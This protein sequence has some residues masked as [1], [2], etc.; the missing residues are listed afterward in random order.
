[1]LRVTL[2]L[3][4]L[5][6]CGFT[7][8]NPTTSDGDGGTMGMD[9]GD[10]D[11][12]PDPTCTQM[13]TFTASNFDPCAQGEPL[14]VL[15]LDSAMWRYSSID[16]SLARDGAV[17]M[18]LPTNGSNPRVLSLAGL[19]VETG[20]V[21][22][23][24]GDAP[25]IIGVHGTAMI[26]GRLDVSGSIASAGAGGDTC[27]GNKGADTSPIPA[28]GA[29]G[30]GG[31]GAFGS[32]GAAGGTGDTE[33]GTTNT[34]GGAAMAEV[35]D[36]MLVP[37]RGG[38]RGGAGGEEDPDAQSAGTPGSGGGG[39]GALQ[40][41]ARDMLEIGMAGRVA[42]NGGGGGRGVNAQYNGGPHV[43]VGGGG[44]GS[45]GAI[46]LESAVVSM[47][48]QAILCANGGGGGGGSH[49]N[50]NNA[51]GANGACSADAAIGGAG[52]NAGGAGGFLSTP[53]MPG[54]PGTRQDDGGGG[55]G[56]GVGRIRVRSISAAPGTFL[57]TPPAVID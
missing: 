23:I 30:G 57:S 36:P 47:H 39:G 3:L 9:G 7:I 25:V 12:L 42:A 8:T 18:T 52:S 6:A 46:F 15:T 48:A 40:I 55:G 45:G 16:G 27:A 41:T 4:V 37:L 10:P 14:P 50:D 19:V 28:W 43:G 54:F 20:A 44:G 26:L 5:E 32:A 24:D 31:G 13:W 56:G 29:G 17:V 11:M 1:M 33:N 2:L 53:P 51:N 35:G 38:C 34:P 22:S 21:V 49:N